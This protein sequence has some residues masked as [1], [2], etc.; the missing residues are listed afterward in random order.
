MNAKRGI[1]KPMECEDRVV[2]APR[3]D[4]VTSVVFRNPNTL[5]QL[6]KAWSAC[7][8]REPRWLSWAGLGTRTSLS[9]CALHA[10]HRSPLR[11]MT[12]MIDESGAMA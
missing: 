9:T 2:A 8:V 1:G 3:C 4:G 11:W 10:T 12:M 5:S 7:S 6:S